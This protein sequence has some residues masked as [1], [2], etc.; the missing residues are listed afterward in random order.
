MKDEPADISCD[1]IARLLENHWGFHA[2]E[3]TYAPVG[4]GCYHWIAAMGD[5]TRWF[6][7]ANYLNPAGSW[8]GPTA[9]HTRTATRAAARAT[10][11]LADRGYEFA[12]ASLPDRD[13]TLVRDILPNWTLEVRPYLDGQRAGDGAWTDPDDRSQIAGILGRLHAAKP[14]EALLS[15]DSALPGRVALLTALGRLDQPWT[16]GPY[17]E[18]TRRLLAGA[19]D[20]IHRRLVHYDDLVRTIEASDDPWVVTHGE[21]HSANVLRTPDG[22]LRLIDWDSAMLAPRERDLAALEEDGP[23]DYLA[24]YQEHAGPV[25]PRPEA[26]EMYHLW[27][28]LAEISG[29][30]QLFREPHTDSLDSEQSWLNLNQYVP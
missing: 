24:A 5:G 25:G 20:G 3:V 4:F 14:P 15:W 9:E 29:Y 19:L 18:P 12:A 21:P 10:K 1:D 17:A 16:T 2:T 11:E 6:V 7:T 23:S 8:L 27:W 22:R 13:D 26:I 30:V 28:A